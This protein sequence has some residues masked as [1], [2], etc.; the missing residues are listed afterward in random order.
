[1]CFRNNRMFR[2]RAITV[3]AQ[4]RTQGRSSLGRRPC[5]VLIR[6]P[7]ALVEVVGIYG[8]ESM[9][10]TRG[11]GVVVVDVRHRSVGVDAVVEM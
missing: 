3:G 2:R 6:F 1:M 11:K 10:G 7:I 9:M 5:I 8:V 4:R